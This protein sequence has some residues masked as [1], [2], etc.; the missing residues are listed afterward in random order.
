MYVYLVSR[1]VGFWGGANPDG[2]MK[3]GPASRDIDPNSRICPHANRCS[4]SPS[5]S[6]KSI[7]MRHAFLH[8][9]HRLFQAPSDVHLLVESMF[10]Q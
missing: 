2:I 5:K 7:H 9:L 4:Q 8:K 10:T 6:L 3:E 1:S